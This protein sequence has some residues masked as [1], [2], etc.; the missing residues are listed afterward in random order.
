MKGIKPTCKNK[1]IYFSSGTSYRTPSYYSMAS[2]RM[3]A[4]PSYRNEYNPTRNDVPYRRSQYEM[5]RARKRLDIF[6]HLS[7]RENIYL[8]TPGTADAY[9][10]LSGSSGHSADYH[11]RIRPSARRVASA[12]TEAD[13]R[14]YNRSRSMDRKQAELEL[15]CKN[16]EAS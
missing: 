3:P 15:S 2:D 10:Q 6:T 1:M 7:W 11:S 4:V 12:L 16:F 5:D 9:M 14:A 8:V 13:R